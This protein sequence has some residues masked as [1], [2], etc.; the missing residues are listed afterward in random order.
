SL[1]S[2]RRAPERPDVDP[3]TRESYTHELIS[4][5]WWPGGEVFPD[6][7][8]YGYI[9]PEPEGF[10]RAQVGPPGTF[11][12][13]QAKGWRFP[14]DR[15][16][17]SGNPRR[18]ALEFFMGMYEAGASLARWDRQALERPEAEIVAP[19]SEEHPAP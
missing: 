13:Q 7:A 3:I 1:F 6:P 9:A 11:S 2:G 8:F 12:A 14:H 15:A 16:R 17:R 10:A 5:G 18:A 4:V 19:R